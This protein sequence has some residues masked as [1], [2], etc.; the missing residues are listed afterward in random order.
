MAFLRTDEVT[1]SSGRT[2][3]Y[4]RIVESVRKKGKVKQK[5]IAN[6]GN[7]AVLRKDIKQIVN[8]LLKA[9]GEKP[10]TFAEDGQLIGTKEYG[11][12]YVAQVIWERLGLQE[13]IKRHLKKRG[14]SVQYEGWSLMMVVNKLSDPVSKLGIFRWLNGIYWP[15]HGFNPLLFKDG[16]TEEEYLECAKGEVMKFYRAMDYLLSLKDTIEI[17]L[18]RQLRD[19]FSLKVDLVFYDLTSSYFEGNGPEGL[20]GLGYSRDHEPGKKQIVIGLIMCNGMPI[21]H[22]VFEGN[23][24]DKKTVTEIVKDLKEKFQ[25]E[26][27]IFVGDRGLVTKENLEEIERHGFDSIIALRKRRNAEVK[28]IV[29]DAT[30]HVYCIDNKELW[31]REVKTA[32]GIRYIV[33]RNPEVAELQKQMREENIKALM[34][35]LKKI[36][37]RIEKLK[38]KASLKRVVGQAEEVLRHKHGRRLIGYTADEKD[39]RLSYWIK[40]ESIKIEEAL[41]GVYILRTEEQRMSAKEVIEAYKDLTDVERAFRTMKSALQL[42]PFYHW[43]ENRVRAHALICYLAFLIE[44]YVERTLKQHNVG[45]SAGTAFESLSQLGAA[46]MEVDEERYT[47]ISEPSRRDILFFNALGLKF[48]TRCMIEK[49]KGIM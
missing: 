38:G 27:C 2:H 26:R 18:Y 19:L 22:E 9:C 4:L 20:A 13:I 40:E 23:R 34:H 49:T 24:V 37:E 35:E 21:G 1:S 3:T 11:V 14:A 7:I 32:Q 12:R 42:R 31:W 46:V 45:F 29:L 6:L 48:P 30:P 47:Y 33:C 25:I 8:G 36:K 5:T 17:H 41:D 28:E 16:I 10:L 44:R 15:G 43:T 39:G